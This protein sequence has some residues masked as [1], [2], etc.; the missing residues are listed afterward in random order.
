MGDVI[1]E[2]NGQEVMN[3]DQLQEIMRKANGNITLKIL[4]T[5]R[6]QN[7][8]SQVTGSLLMVISE[9]FFISVAFKVHQMLHD[10]GTHLLTGVDLSRILKGQTQILGS[11]LW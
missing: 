8:F 7:S 9:R 10:F 4:P 1:K 3:P 2:I 6:D 11:E 5:T